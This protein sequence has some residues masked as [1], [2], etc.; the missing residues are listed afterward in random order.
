MR[1]AREANGGEGVGGGRGGWKV[2]GDI[3]LA[4]TWYAA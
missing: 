2:A 4:A 1:V 3:A